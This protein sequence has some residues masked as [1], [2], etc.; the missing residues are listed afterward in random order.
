MLRCI[1]DGEPGMTLDELIE[2]LEQ[3]PIGDEDTEKYVS[4]RAKNNE[5]ERINN[6]KSNVI[7]ADGWKNG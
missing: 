1:L 2:S 7:T 3:G 6:E 4:S 5:K